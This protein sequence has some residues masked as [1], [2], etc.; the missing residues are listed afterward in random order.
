MAGTVAVTASAS[1]TGGLLGNWSFTYGAGAP[2]LFLQSITIDLAPTGLAFDTPG[3][4]FGSLSSQDFSSFSFTN[5]GSLAGNWISPDPA[6]NRDGAQVVTLSFQN[7]GPNQTVTFAADVD[8]PNPTP[9]VA[10]TCSGTL[11][12]RI[13][14]AANNVAGQTAYQAALLAAQTVGPNQMAGATVTFEFAGTD[15]FTTDVKGTFQPVTFSEIIAGLTAGQGVSAF[16]TSAGSSADV[17]SPEPAT[18]ATL[19]AGFGLL[20]A[21]AARRRRA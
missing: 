6:A 9:F 11:S 1:F 19:G 17:A 12:Q 15:Y 20:L 13:A 5:G 2:D 8:H 7:F 21:L 3:G 4:A 14:C 16:D 18:L 10:Q